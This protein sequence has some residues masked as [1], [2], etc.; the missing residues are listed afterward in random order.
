MDMATFLRVYQIRARNIM[1]FLGAGASRAAGIKTASDMILDFK[2]NLYRSQKKL[3][4]K[5]IGDLGDPSVRHKLQRYFDDLPN[6]PKGGATD[7]YARYFEFTFEN[8][9]DRRTYL[10][11]LIKLGKPTFGHLALALL[12]REGYCRIVWTTNFDRTVE[13]ASA[14]IY[15]STNDLIVGSLG[16]P[17]KVTESLNGK[18]FP[19]YGKLHGDYHSVALKN[20]DEELREQDSEM[21]RALV[22][23]CKTNGL[24][25]VGYS[26]RD[27]SIID[28][29]REALDEGR[30]YPNGLFWFKRP[31]EVPFEAVTNLIK[32]AC[33]LGVDAHLIDIHTF[34]EL[35]SDIVRFLPKT[36]NKLGDIENA[37]PP[38]LGCVSLKGVGAKLPSIRT[39][40]LPFISHPVMCRLVDCD[41]GG[42]S[43]IQEAILKAGIDILARRTKDGV[44][45]FGSDSDIRTVFG[46]FGIKNFQMRS[47]PD[48]I[49]SYESEERRL[50]RD[51]FMRALSNQSGIKIIHRGRRVFALPNLQVVKPT[52]FRYGDVNPVITLTGTVG[53]TGIRWSECCGLR[54]DYKLDRLWLLINP[55]VYV[56]IPNDANIEQIG[57][58]KEFV[59]SHLASRFNL[60]SNA[61]LSGWARL[62]LGTK[63]TAK[64]CCF[65]T[66]DGIDATFEMSTIT[67]FSGKSR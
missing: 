64:L 28:A 36:A 66:S 62:L 11:Q 2:Q 16:E 61:M 25:V 35:L 58:C 60:M 1:W 42:L 49:L 22:S 55:H 9:N 5:A 47:I 51:A 27:A 17:M 15:G 20:T 43:D 19:I 12:M 10:D 40:A 24:A 34:D 37:R 67:G 23:S 53:T 41:I 48:K 39:N 33:S 52:D 21:R 65:G 56:E 8:A 30:G 38:R 63:R 18:R 4:P 3:S 26:G 46:S 7:E 13:D 44:I 50:I 59:R 29:L 57:E 6:Y 54:L 32:E 14:K 31:N 45:A